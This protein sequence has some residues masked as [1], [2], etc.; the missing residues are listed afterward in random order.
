MIAALASRLRRRGAAEIAWLA[1]RNLVH[2]VRSLAPAERARR[3][4]DGAFDRRWGTDTSGGVSVHDL[5]FAPGMIDHCRRYDPSDETMLRKPVAML[6][7]DP[8]D[9]AFVDYGA[10]KGRM[11]MLAMEMGFASVTGVELSERLCPIARTNV[12]R[13][14]AQHVGMSA[15]QIVQGD[16]TVFEPDGRRL[17]AYFYNPFDATI[18]AAVRARLEATLAER[19][20]RVIVVYANPEHGAVF[21]D[22]PGWKERP[23]PLGVSVFV[24]DQG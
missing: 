16:A 1:V 5:G 21:R 12:A 23:A 9:Y 20:D 7:I 8:S 24:A 2:L 6:G 14:A 13:F 10:G 19:T 22:T 15:A 17:L 4:A 11:V 3:A 18:I